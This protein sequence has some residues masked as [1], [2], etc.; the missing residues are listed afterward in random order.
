MRRK[1]LAS[2]TGLLLAGSLVAAVPSILANDDPILKLQATAIDPGAVTPTGGRAAGAGI[3]EVGINHWTTDAEHARLAAILAEKGPDAFMDALDDL[4]PAGYIR[5]PTSLG[6][7]IHYARQIA[8]PG[9]GR[10][11]IFA[12]D[13]PM[14]FWELWHQ[15]RSAQY[16]YLL[17]EVRVGPDGRGSGTL[18]PAARIDYHEPTR[19]IEIEQYASEPVRLTQVQVQK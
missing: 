2:I 16:E 3:L 13:R 17:G 9:G 11:I 15:P 4:R 18:V 6:W 10:R 19:T 14:G 1:R 5:T 12:T 8:L 7:N